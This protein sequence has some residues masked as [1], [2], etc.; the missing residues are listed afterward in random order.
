MFS[1]VRW[2][3][4][5]YF[6]HLV[7]ATSSTYCP[8]SKLGNTPYFWIIGRRWVLLLTIRLQLCC[9]YFRV[10]TS[11]MLTVWMV[12][13]TG[14]FWRWFFLWKC[15]ICGKYFCQ[16]PT[17][18][19]DERCGTATLLRN[20]F[21]QWCEA[22]WKLWK[23]FIAKIT[24]IQYMGLFWPH[25]SAINYFNRMKQIHSLIC[26]IT[27]HHWVRVFL[28]CDLAH[29]VFLLLVVMPRLCLPVSVLVV[30]YSSVMFV[31]VV[32]HAMVCCSQLH[33]CF[34]P[35]VIQHC[36]RMKLVKSVCR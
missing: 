31:H 26:E 24:G 25:S 21:F 8:S 17:R 19:Q 14:L 3:L 12:T 33:V 6:S 23:Y 18:G 15:S 22:T 7:I 29:R 4:Q 10:D 28:H 35:R 1:R 30:M 16:W 20:K 13:Y 2:F 11:I 32:L 34:C 36:M 9:E 5:R 27:V